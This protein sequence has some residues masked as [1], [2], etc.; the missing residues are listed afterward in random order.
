MDKQTKLTH[1]GRP[2]PKLSTPVN[3]EVRRASTLLFADAD[4]LYR[5]DIMTYGRHGSDVHQGLEDAFTELEDGFGTVLTAS[6]LEAC[7]LALLA[8]VEAGDHILITD[9]IYGPTRM[10]CEGYLKKLGIECERFDP[11][12]GADIENLIR[13]N[14]RLIFL[15]SPGSLTLEIQDI[16]AIC[17][18]ARERDVLT[19]VDNTWSA[20]IA[21][22]PLD[23]GADISIHSATKY[24]G[25]HGDVFGGA[26]I[27]REEKIHRRIARV[28]KY[29]GM[30]LSADDAYQLLRGF[31]TLFTRY[32]A[33]AE[34]A[35]QLA[36]W[37]EGQ[38]EVR[39]VIH[40]A[41][42]SHPDHAL[43]LRDFS[44]GSSLFSFTMRDEDP[45]KIVKFINGLYNFGIGFSY[46]GYESVIIHCD[47][48]LNRA[49]SP[50][51]DGPLIRIGCGL[52]ILNDLKDDIKQSLDATY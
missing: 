16:P 37:L 51:H 48:Q 12:I 43:W 2:H 28:R 18:I 33:Q 15:E 1:I 39:S 21:Y 11:R 31:R 40:P 46:G 17:T 9:S 30:S 8:F 27:S 10:F 5:Q 35:L 29:I 25:G 24:V 19:M 32:Q 3:P 38:D 45:K 23:L 49:F 36:T 14:T 47:P 20:G 6:G 41:L 44:A 22:K 4:D 13:D 7:T 50:A 34:T 42:P 52:Q 26:V